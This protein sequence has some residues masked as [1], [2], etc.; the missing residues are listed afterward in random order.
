MGQVAAS[1]GYWIASTADKIVAERT[2]ITG[3]IGVIGW[4]P[5]FERSLEY[6]GLYVDGVGTTDYADP[7]N[8][9]REPNVSITTL[10]ERSVER[11]YS[12]FLGLV[13]EGR[14]I[15]YETVKT[16]AQ[17]RVWSAKD[18]LEHKLADQLGT[19]DD[20]VLLAAKLAE[21]E[22]WDRLYIEKQK[23]YTERFLK[24]LMKQVQLPVPF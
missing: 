19:L 14:D 21:L 1:G 6:L 16:I 15:P 4:I 13:S 22:K 23:T 8:P 24:E 5:S 18:A 12:R 9:F 11:I 2:T 17:G 3:S 20:A 10:A 7:Y